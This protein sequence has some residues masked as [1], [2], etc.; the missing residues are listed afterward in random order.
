MLSSINY[1]IIMLFVLAI[2][3]IQTVFHPDKFNICFFKI[4]HPSYYLLKVTFLDHATSSNT[5]F[6]VAISLYS[7]NIFLI[8]CK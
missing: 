2:A 1:F 3:S 6:S 5:D 7:E 4:A 8:K